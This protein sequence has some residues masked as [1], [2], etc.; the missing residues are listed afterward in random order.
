[1]ASEL[2]GK[3]TGPI[4]SAFGAL[5]TFVQWALIGVPVLLICGWVFY[6]I[7]IKKKKYNLDIVFN[8]VRSDG[9]I[10]NA[11]LGKGQYNTKKGFI[12]LKRPRTAGHIEM[13][14]ADPKKYIYG[15]NMMQ[16]AQIGPNTWVPIH[17]DSLSQYVNDKNEVEYFIDIKTDLTDQL[18]WAES[19]K[20]RAKGT[21]S[22]MDF[23][24]KYQT[25][26]AIGFVVLAQAIST[27]FIIA[28]IK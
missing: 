9:K 21:F 27:A 23:L 26:I 10:V 4:G 2:L 28:V 15:T 3:V 14:P 20:T 1:M 17:P 7:V 6:A 19:F 16:V 18:S 25:P 5:G 22:I 11:E 13:K 8:M 12:L 24:Q